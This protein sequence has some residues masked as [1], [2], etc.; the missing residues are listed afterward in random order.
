MLGDGGYE[1][2]EGDVRALGAFYENNWWFDTAYY[3]ALRFRMLN[4]PYLDTD[5]PPSRYLQYKKPIHTS[6]L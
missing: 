1:A 2:L 5:K 6:P 3:M 4:G